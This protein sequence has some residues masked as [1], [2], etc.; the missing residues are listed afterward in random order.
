MSS[1]HCSKPE[2]MLLNDQKAGMKGLDKERINQIIYEAT[3]DSPFYKHQLE[4]EKRINAQ[5]EKMLSTMKSLS[6]EQKNKARQTMDEMAAA[7]ESQRNDLKHIIVHLDMDMFYAAVEMRDDPSLREKPIAVG[8]LSMLATSNYEA[9]KFG[10]RAAMPGF[11]AKRLCPSLKIISCN[12]HKYCEV[13]DEV[14]EILSDY[15]PDYSSAG[16]DEAYLDITQYVTKKLS[17]LDL[18]SQLDCDFTLNVFPKIMWDIAYD[19]VN[20]I[21]AKILEKTKLTSSAGIA[22]NKSLAKI[23]SDLNKPNGQFMLNGWDFE[24]VQTFVRNLEARK[25]PGIGPV[26]E[27]YLKALDIRTCKDL[28]EKRDLIYLLFTPCLVEFYLRTSLGIHST[29]VKS[30]DESSRKSKGSERTFKATS[31]LDALSKILKSLSEDVSISLKKHG[32]KG[33]TV[34][35][36]LKRDTFAAFVRSKTLLFY[37]ND[38]EVF[39][40]TARSILLTQLASNSNE[41]VAFRL[42]GI[43]VCNFED[44]CTETKNDFIKDEK[45]KQLTL[46]SFLTKNTENDEVVADAIKMNHT[47]GFCCLSFADEDA[48]ELHFQK[49]QENKG[50]TMICPVCGI[51]RF[52]DL[53]ELNKHIDCCLSDNYIKES[54]QHKSVNEMNTKRKSD[55]EKQSKHAKIESYFKR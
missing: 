24:E 20:E 33:R 17:S 43:R 28:W 50:S 45:K 39:Y 5:I 22:P 47:C 26:Q 12:F 35:L 34:T 49:C 6:D 41:D 25:I 40:Q 48:L 7:L 23:C 4:K 9:R 3:K 42:M 30:Y 10:V 53:S 16:L 29:C 38:A 13:S 27:K 52:S 32:L 51:E 8:S 37:T 31:N 18:E 55:V 46:D 15:D 14:M 11:I 36:K 1:N 2:L 21:R 19:V 54:F 44:D